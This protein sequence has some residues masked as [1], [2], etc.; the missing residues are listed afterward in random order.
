[1][2]TLEQFDVSLFFFINRQLVN[3]FLDVVSVWLRNK[4]FW[5]P[6]YVFIASFFFKKYQWNAFWIIAFAVLTILFSDQLSASVFKP[7]FARLRPCNQPEISASVRLLVHC[8]SGF[9]FVSSHAANHSALSVFLLCFFEKKWVK[10]LLVFWAFCV[11]FSQVYV[12]V[13]YPSDVLCGGVLGALIGA[14]NSAVFNF[15]IAG[16]LGNPQ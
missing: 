9:S 4:F 15:T 2:E 7:L 11:A 8:G 14:V 6:V 5:V 10:F 12:G 16:K 3:S 13:H 1:M